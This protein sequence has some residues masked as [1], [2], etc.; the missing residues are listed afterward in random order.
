MVRISAKVCEENSPNSVGH[1][2]GTIYQ[3]AEKVPML[4]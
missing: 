1:T 4:V 3:H 2:K